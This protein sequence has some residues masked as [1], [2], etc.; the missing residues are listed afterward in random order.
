MLKHFVQAAHDVDGF[1]RDLPNFRDEAR[2]LGF[3]PLEKNLISKSISA[4][5]LI[6]NI[7]L[8]SRRIDQ[9][10]PL[11][12]TNT[13]SIGLPPQRRPLASRAQSTHS[14]ACRHPMAGG[15]RTQPLSDHIMSPS[16]LSNCA[17]AL[18]PHDH[19]SFP[20]ARDPAD[21]CEGLTNYDIRSV[22]ASR[23]I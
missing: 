20:S 8:R 7:T 19:R 11:L 13:A 3:G 4:Q 18:A 1:L 5:N 23:R 2:D 9:P 21:L 12:P 14:R 6:Y 10:F 15:H 22:A 17:E 16:L